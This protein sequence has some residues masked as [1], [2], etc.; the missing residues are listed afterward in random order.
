MTNEKEQTWKIIED[1][2]QSDVSDQLT[3]EI[4]IERERFWKEKLS[5]EKQIDDLKSKVRLLEQ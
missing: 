1:W 2:K 4:R 3:D 5:Y